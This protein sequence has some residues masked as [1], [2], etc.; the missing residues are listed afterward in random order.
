MAKLPSKQITIR[1]DL[2]DWVRILEAAEQAGIKPVQFVRST[3]LRTLNG[4]LVDAKSID[5]YLKQ[6]EKEEFHKRRGH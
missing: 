6:Q 2:S 1:F 4:H 3:V 5:A